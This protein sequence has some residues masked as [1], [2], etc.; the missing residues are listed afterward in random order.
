M[1]S[2]ITLH[3]LKRGTYQIIPE[4]EQMGMVGEARE[5]VP[6]LHDTVKTVHMNQPSIPLADTGL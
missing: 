6:Q 2:D 5:A 4:C 1:E 3:C